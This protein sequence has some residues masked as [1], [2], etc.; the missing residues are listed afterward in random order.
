MPTVAVEVHPE[1]RFLLQPRRR[2]E[3]FEVDVPE[4]DTVGHLVQMLAVPLT[5]VGALLLDGR[6]VEPSARFRLD[7]PVTLTVEPRPRP[8]P[9][10]HSPTRFLLDVHLGSLL[11]RLRLLGLDA[12]YDSDAADDQL[13]RWAI[14]EA[15]VLLTRDRD[16]L[17]RTALPEGALVRG[18]STEDQLDD[19]LARFA[20]LLAPWTRCIRCNA[21]LSPVER[22]QVADEL[23]PGTRRTYQEFSRCTGC[24]RVYWR[25]AHSGPLEAVV[26]RAEAIVA[27]PTHRPG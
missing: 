11:R 15:R 21:T 12:A 6:P 27:A 20:A 2:R 19:V 5:E 26:R 9:T 24:G 3:R 23:E 14:A 10:Q 18:D 8:Q 1:L 17:S 25:G 22:E 16:L 7:R 13:V 4:T